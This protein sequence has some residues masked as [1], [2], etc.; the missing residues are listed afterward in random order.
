MLLLQF[1]EISKTWFEN[2]GWTQPEEAEKFL[3]QF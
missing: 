1:R 2:V 3:M